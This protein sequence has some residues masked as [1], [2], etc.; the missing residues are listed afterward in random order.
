[1]PAVTTAEFR[2]RFPE[3]QESD[4]PDDRVELYIDIAR[5]NYNDTAAEAVLL[6][7]A[8]LLT[9]L[10]KREV[11]SSKMGSIST[12]FSVVDPVWG[13]THY[14]RA[15]IELESRLPHLGIQIY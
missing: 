3:L 9:S 1:M 15:Y 13:S 5:T 8:H 7:T 10:G 11:Q 12:S 14:G 4:Y 2:T 6:A